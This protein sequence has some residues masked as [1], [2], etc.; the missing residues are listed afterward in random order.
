MRNNSLQTGCSSRHA[1][2]EISEWNAC[3]RP[4]SRNGDQTRKVACWLLLGLLVL[5]VQLALGGR[6][7]LL[8][9][10]LFFRLEPL[11]LCFETV[12]FASIEFPNTVDSFALVLRQAELSKSIWQ[13]SF[14]RANAPGIEKRPFPPNAAAKSSAPKTRHRMSGTALVR[15]RRSIFKPFGVMGLR[16]Q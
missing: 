1:Q 15:R 11:D 3:W 12:D 2:H 6:Q 4:D 9:L 5:E 16:W 13:A 14:R 8:I 10:Q 7:N